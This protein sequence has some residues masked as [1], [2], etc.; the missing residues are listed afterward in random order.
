MFDEA[1]FY[2]VL[3][4]AGMTSSAAS[5][6]TPSSPAR[7]DLASSPRAVDSRIPQPR[8]PKLGC[9]YRPSP[10][11]PPC[12]AK[13]RIRSWSS[14]FSTSQRNNILSEIPPENAHILL[15]TMLSSL[16]EPTRSCYAAG[17]LRYTQF[18][19]GLDVSEERRVPASETLLASFIA[20]WAGKISSSTTSNWLAGLHFWHQYQGAQWH[21]ANMLRITQS[22]V[23]KL[24]PPSSRRPKRSPVTLQHMH[25]LVNGLDRNNPFDASVLGSTTTAF[26]GAC[27]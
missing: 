24:V 20:S 21:G 25:C 5:Q 22:G 10:F 18:C 12:L 3:A 4:S 26:W 15:D 14:P 7:S 19:D 27:R 1:T 6:F 8:K 9:N 13:D 2:Q 23:D 11:R 17:L 16:D